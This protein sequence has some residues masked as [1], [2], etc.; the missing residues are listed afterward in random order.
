MIIVK[1]NCL[2][3][4]AAAKIVVGHGCTIFTFCV[5]AIAVLGEYCILNY[6]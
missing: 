5:L 4:T 6:P 3:G 2:V 1:R